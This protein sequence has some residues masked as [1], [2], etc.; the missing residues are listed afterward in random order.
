[1]GSVGRDTGA[2]FRSVGRATQSRDSAGRDT[3]KAP[4]QGLNQVGK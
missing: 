2:V 3:G 4:R 1:M